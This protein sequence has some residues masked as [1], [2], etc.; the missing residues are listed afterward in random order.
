M[1]WFTPCLNELIKISVRLTSDEKRRQALQFAGLGVTSLPTVALAQT[2]VQ[3]GKWFPTS[4]SKGRFLGAAA[5]GG[6]FWGGA[7]PAMQHRISQTNL[8]RAKARV[9]STKELQ[10]L[11]PGGVKKTLATLPQASTLPRVSHV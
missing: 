7:L 1:D 3:T 6:A 2:K 11:T 5:L 4:M 8:E 10:S 9:Q